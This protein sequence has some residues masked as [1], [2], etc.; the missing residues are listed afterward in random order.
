MGDENLDLAL[1]VVAALLVALVG[2]T[3][4]QRFSGLIYIIL[5]AEINIFWSGLMIPFRWVLFGFIIL[6]MYPLVVAVL[7]RDILWERL[8]FRYNHPLYGIKGFVYQIPL[9]KKP[10]EKLRDDTEEN[11]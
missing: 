1:I 8:M 7:N 3:V 5:N 4:N 9:V 11:K 2:I 6:L 10:S